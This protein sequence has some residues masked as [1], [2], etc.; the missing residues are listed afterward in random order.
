MKIARTIVVSIAMQSMRQSR[1][2]VHV[3]HV[4]VSKVLIR[5]GAIQM[6]GACGA[7]LIPLP[8]WHHSGTTVLSYSPYM[9]SPDYPTTCDIFLK[10]LTI[11]LS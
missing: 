3:V 11:F 4:T 1:G 2:Q 10:T 5:E 7:A 6:E 8:G 9:A